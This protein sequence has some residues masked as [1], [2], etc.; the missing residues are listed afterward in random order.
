MLLRN[1]SYRLGFLLLFLQRIKYLH[2]FIWQ[3]FV[4]K[5]IYSKARMQAKQWADLLR[6]KCHAVITVQGFE[7]TT[8]S[9][10]QYLLIC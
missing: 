8:W 4:S 7:F 9:Q 10:A 2:M 6:V 1:N 3:L 5:E